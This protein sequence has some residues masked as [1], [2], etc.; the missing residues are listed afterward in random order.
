MTTNTSISKTGKPFWLA[1]SSRTIFFFLLVL[2][3]AGI[4]GAFQVPISVFPDTNF[5][6]V[7]IGID[8]GVMPVEQMQLTITKPIEDAVNSVPGLMTVRSTTSRGSAE[9]S[10]FFNWNVD[11]FHTL[12]LTDAALAKVQQTLPAT[13]RI[14]TNRLTFATFPILG[15][16]LTA[17]DRGND[18]VSQTRLWEIATYDLKP[19]LN[20]VEGVSTVT[21]QGGQ[22]PEFH[23][24]PNLARLQAS[25]VTMLDLVNGVQASNIIDSPGLYEADHQLILGLIG[26]QAH[27]A[28]QLGNLVIKTTAAGAPVRVADVATVERATMPVYTMVTANGAPSVLLNIARQPSSNTVTVANAVASEIRSLQSKLPPGVHLEA[29]YDQ[30]ELVRES[31]SSVRDAI[32]IGLI[33]ACVILFLFLRDW[34]S[35]LVAGLVIPVTVAITI[36]FLWLIGQSF[37]LMTLGGLAAAIGLVIDDAIVVVENIVVHRDRGESRIEAVRKALH[38][39][40]VPLIGSTITPVVVFLP[41][42]SV[43]GVTGSFFRAL[44]VTMT[45]A[46]LTSLLLALTWTPA[47]SLSLLRSSHATD[48][49]KTEH[50]ENGPIMRRILNAHERT[51]T[52]ALVHPFYLALACLTLIFVGYLGY[53]SLGSDLLPAMDEGAFVLDYT[54]PAG[55]SLTETNRVL[56]H[57]EQI[58]R[59]TP[60]VLITSR[61]TGLQM[62]LAAVTEANYGDFT[63]R[64]KTKRSRSIDE[65][66]ADVRAQVKATE[67]ELDVEF[68]QVLQDMIGDLSN[69]PEP[70]QIKLFANDQTLLND[71]GPRVQAAISKIPGVVDTQNGIDNTLSGPA[72]SFQID[73]VLAGRLGFTPTEVAED[74]TAILDGLPTNDPLILDGR[75]YT[76]R[77]RLPQQNRTSLNAI[78]NTVFNSSTGHTATLGSMAQVTQLPPQN[79]IRRENLQQLILVSGRLE[80]SDLGSAMASVRQT[81]ANMHLPSSVRVEYGGTYEEQQ[82]SFRDLARVLLLAL[83]LV[84][85]VLLAE[86]RNLSAPIAILTSSVLS[87][88]GVILALLITQTSFNVASFMGLIMVIGIVAKNG[89]LLLDADEKYRSEEPSGSG[90]FA[91]EAMIHA[92]QRRLRP[93]VMTAIAAVCGMLPL[94]FALG[95]GSQMLQ[96]LAIAVIGGLLVSIFLSLIVT[97]VIYYRLTRKR[98]H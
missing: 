75:P 1:Q 8:N 22:T 49:A 41:L 58:L 70:I 97:P 92:A 50:E 98:A 73:P 7:V 3:C 28:S 93:I 20:R 88:T 23:L 30:S 5:P 80:G 72:T 40:T 84:F 46:L 57:V 37:N 55:S 78:Q 65:V 69:S 63:V 39:I 42:I 19:P 51:L 38:E 26:A 87:M 45:A 32:F 67:P 33:L 82:K 6:R 4:Y 18:T 9:I 76:I 10:L 94:A 11:M 54:M 68:T 62:G 85:G 60:E 48:T 27:D 89:I 31:I 74:A 61:R 71:L 13:A 25:G 21:I 81:V 15:Y 16:A 17:D 79:E 29:F 66:M 91:R 36:L 47:L 59:H 90:D 56:Q 86:F 12:Q 14:T 52:W 53:Q 24:V 34:T 95:A 77:V 43:S 64:L 44:A 96:P 83:A 2:T 35:S